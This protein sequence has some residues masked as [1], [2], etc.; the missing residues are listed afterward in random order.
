MHA[1]DEAAKHTFVN[2]QRH[3]HT[4]TQRERG[5]DGKHWCRA[6]CVKGFYISGGAFGFENGRE[7]V[8]DSF[9]VVA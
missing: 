5:R 2:S 6:L 4:H 7:A 1:L 9:F 3:F 8:C